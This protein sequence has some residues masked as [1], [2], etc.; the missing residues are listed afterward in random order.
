MPFE[1]CSSCLVHV[2]LV[3]FSWLLGHWF[4][5]D[6]DGGLVVFVDSDGGLMILPR[7]MVI[8]WRSLIVMVVLWCFDER[9]RGGL[10]VF[11]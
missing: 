2:A 6:S 4:S 7:H 11:R 5:L 10:T 9:K 1:W 8:I 3:A